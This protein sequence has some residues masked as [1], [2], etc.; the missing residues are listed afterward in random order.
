MAQTS[1]DFL[2]R[3]WMDNPFA[4]YEEGVEAYRKANE[5]HKEE[6][7]QS[8]LSAWKDSMINPLEDKYYEPEAEQYYNETYGK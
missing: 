1:V 6:I 5:I 8:W 2:W 4:S 7:K 3:W